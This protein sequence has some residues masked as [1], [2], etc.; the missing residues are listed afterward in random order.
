M[1]FNFKKI[2]IVLFAFIILIMPFSGCLGGAEKEIEN[3]TFENATFNYKKDV[4]HTLEITGELP[5][6]V[7]ATYEN[8]V[9][10]DRGIYDAT[11]TLSGRGYKTKTL[12]A[13]MTIKFND[14]GVYD[15]E[16]YAYRN[17]RWSDDTLIFNDYE[18]A[19]TFSN[20][21]EEVLFAS[22]TTI[23]D[24]T[25][26]KAGLTSAFNSSLLDVDA[27]YQNDL[28]LKIM[29]YAPADVGFTVLENKKLDNKEMHLSIIPDCTKQAFLEADYIEF[30]M[31]Y[32]LGR[33]E[34]MTDP[35]EL[36]LYTSNTKLFYCD[37]NTWV[38]IKI[39]LDVYRS[40]QSTEMS[41]FVTSG[42][43]TGVNSKED[44]YEYLCS[45]KSFLRTKVNLRNI[46]SANTQYKIYFS[47]FK[48]KVDIPD[49]KTNPLAPKLANR[50]T[51]LDEYEYNE[52]INKS[53]LKNIYPRYSVLYHDTHVVEYDGIDGIVKIDLSTVSRTKGNYNTLMNNL[54]VNVNPSKTYKQIAQYDA[55]AITLRI[56]SQ[57]PNPYIA[58]SS[59]PTQSN[60][61]ENVLARFEANKWV[62]F[63]IP[64]EDVLNMYAGL[65]N[66]YAYTSPSNSYVWTNDSAQQLFSITYEVTE[67]NST[68]RASS[69]Y[70]SRID[71]GGV[72][73]F[74]SSPSNGNEYVPVKQGNWIQY[75]MTVYFKSIKLIKKS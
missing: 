10:T 25:K 51:K 53:I 1:K 55:L 24:N 3:V 64:I 21:H 9:H 15:E 50:F 75:P 20:G 63:E 54:Y 11:C 5:N 41:T 14:Y 56:D 8:N 57:N 13:N 44:F 28:G 45:G 17:S 60:V 74:T 71:K 66:A 67:G 32:D 38:K 22:S 58:L 4:A 7:T 26:T 18:K 61:K 40:A 42:G 72:S 62:T 19:G 68:R 27:Y 59:V 12:K 47:D 6:G 30:Y 34:A 70:S 2:A 33:Y 65:K 23:N 48:L 49:N 39:P 37:E 43:G 35:N 52:Q 46:S 36:T 29:N 16:N 69:L 73:K 31:F